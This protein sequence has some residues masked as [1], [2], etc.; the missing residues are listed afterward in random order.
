[1]QTFILVLIVLIGLYLT[2]KLTKALVSVLVC[3]VLI[4]LGAYFVLPLVLDPDRALAFEEMEAKTKHVLEQ[5]FKK[6]KSFTVDEIVA[7]LCS[8]LEPVRQIEQEIEKQK[9]A[10]RQ[11]PDRTNGPA[12]RSQ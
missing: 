1:M 3:L 5:N 8:K 10:S 11:A 4:A 12:E 7:P 6:A 2:W 9:R